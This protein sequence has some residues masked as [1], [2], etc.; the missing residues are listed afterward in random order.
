MEAIGDRLEATEIRLKDEDGI[1]HRNVNNM[2]Q[3]KDPRQRWEIR[4]TLKNGSFIR[5]S[6]RQVTEDN[7]ATKDHD[8]VANMNKKAEIRIRMMKN[9]GK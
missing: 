6:E 1:G 5:K 8:G 7:Y 2:K 9:V 4:K 3:K